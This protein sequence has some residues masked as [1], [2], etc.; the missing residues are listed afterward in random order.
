MTALTNLT[1]RRLTA[2]PSNLSR[3]RLTAAP[4]NPTWAGH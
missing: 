2:A 3:R 1:L 4:A